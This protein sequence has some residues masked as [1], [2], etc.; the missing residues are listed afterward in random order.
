M[1]PMP[2]LVQ[3]VSENS[4]SCSLIIAFPLLVGTHEHH[5]TTEEGKDLRKE[6][7]L[8]R[9]VEKISERVQ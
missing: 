5:F 2:F 8:F 9:D 7:N 6:E 1:K 3:M 4:S